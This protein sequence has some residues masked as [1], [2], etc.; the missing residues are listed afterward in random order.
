MYLGV[1]IKMVQNELTVTLAFF[2]GL[3]RFIPMDVIW[4]GVYTWPHRH[5][6]VAAAQ[7]NNCLR[8]FA[9]PCNN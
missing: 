2:S 9:T 5:A 1:M 3:S 4:S 7:S 8:L 6:E